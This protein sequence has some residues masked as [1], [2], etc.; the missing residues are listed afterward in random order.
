MKNHE[1]K[2]DETEGLSMVEWAEKY[3]GKNG[4]TWYNQYAFNGILFLLREPNNES[5]LSD[6]DS[7]IAENSK[8]LSK[9]IGSHPSV[10]TKF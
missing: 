10:N 1:V 7:V 8:W 9:V 6:S 2:I 4:V 5:N 3:K